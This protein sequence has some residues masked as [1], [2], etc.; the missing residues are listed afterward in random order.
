MNGLCRWS[1][2][3]VCVCVCRRRCWTYV[4]RMLKCG[5]LL[6]LLCP[7]VAGGRSASLSP[8]EPQQLMFMKRRDYGCYNICIYFIQMPVRC[9]TTAKADGWHTGDRQ[10]STKYTETEA[11]AAA[12]VNIRC[13]QNIYMNM[14]EGWGKNWLGTYW[15]KW[16]T[17]RMRYDKH[18]WPL[19]P[20]LHNFGLCVNA[21]VYGVFSPVCLCGWPKWLL[22]NECAPIV[23]SL[24]ALCVCVCV[25]PQRRQRRTV[26]AVQRCHFYLTERIWKVMPFIQSFYHAMPCFAS[27]QSSIVSL[28]FCMHKNSRWLLTLAVK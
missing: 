7:L 11:S 5:I 25:A 3:T 26:T 18:S 4:H 6:S 17:V 15:K 2:L 19:P 10:R 23:S 1:F 14:R 8:A 22:V 13:T 28:S 12:A 9:H 20:S 21:L 24:L 16:E 27:V